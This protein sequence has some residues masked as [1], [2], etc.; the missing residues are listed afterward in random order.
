[1]LMDEAGNPIYLGMVGHKT[2]LESIRATVQARQRKKL[3]LQGRPVYPLPTHHSQAW[4]H[5]PDY[6]AYHA[7]LIAD[8]AL[9]G[10]WQPGEEVIYNLIFEGELLD[11]SKPAT[12]A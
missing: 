11:G 6:G 2:V 4:Q 12:Q 10:K 9:P 8:P 1:M 3:W 5:L 7:T